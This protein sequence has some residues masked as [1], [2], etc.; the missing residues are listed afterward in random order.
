MITNDG[1]EEKRQNMLN[2]MEKS[3]VRIPAKLMREVV[4]GKIT[5][6]AHFLYC[7]L[8]YRQGRNPKYWGGVEDICW[9]TGISSAQISRLL[10]QLEL[11]GHIKRGK[12]VG[13]TWLTYCLTHVDGGKIYFRGQVIARNCAERSVKNGA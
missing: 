12:R 5:T 6:T 8:L 11:R 4:E 7:Y 13:R 9:G 1:R 10:K 3:F 2:V